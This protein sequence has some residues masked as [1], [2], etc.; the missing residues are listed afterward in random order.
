MRILRR[1]KSAIATCRGQQSVW[2]A[3]SKLLADVLPKYQVQGVV[4]SL[5]L[6]LV[7][8]WRSLGLE[9]PGWFV[10]EEME[11]EKQVSAC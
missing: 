3:T 11:E 7:L 2:I 5:V 8:L 1:T 4:V 9:N 10:G 6:L